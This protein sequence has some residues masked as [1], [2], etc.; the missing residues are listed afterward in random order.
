MDG[1]LA[2]V[3]IVVV[4]RAGRAMI[5]HCGRTLELHIED[6]CSPMHEALRINSAWLRDRLASLGLTQWW[7]AEQIGVDRRT[8]MRWANGQVRSIRKENAVALADVLDC[9]V[10]HLLEVQGAASLGSVDDQRAAARALAASNVLDRLGPAHQWS[11]AETVLK[12]SAVGDLPPAILGRLYYQLG[13]DV[14]AAGQ[15]AEARVHNDAALT[16]AH[17]TDDRDSKCVRSAAERA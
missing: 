6:D 15:L 7:V 5:A 17:E 14:L 13:V 8:V 2:I 4:R 9:Q 11:V 1:G 3:V 12:A 16:I 10:H